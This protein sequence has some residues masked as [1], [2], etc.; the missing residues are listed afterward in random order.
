MVLLL[1]IT[2]IRT[3][4]LVDCASK[5]HKKLESNNTLEESEGLQTGAT[6]REFDREAPPAIAVE[7]PEPMTTGGDKLGL[8]LLAWGDC[9]V[10]ARVKSASGDGELG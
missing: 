8:D 10:R 6:T 5:K 7:T 4:L 1:S 9:I 3:K 2:K